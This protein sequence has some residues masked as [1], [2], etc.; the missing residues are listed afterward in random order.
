MKNGRA[1]VGVMLFLVVALV[2]AWPAAEAWAQ[3]AKEVVVGYTGPISGVAAEYG[4]DCLNGIA[5][6]VN[7]INP[8]GG[9]TIK[10]QKYQFKLVKFDDMIDPTQ[11]V[12]NCR[13]FRDQYK[14]PAVFNPV[15]NTLAAM[16][17]IN[18]EKGN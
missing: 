2:T 17:K 6:A 18:Q 9:V 15:F 11:A 16:A 12:N 1:F 13:R 5:M 14:A 3:A 8:A 4:Q 10:G 7:E